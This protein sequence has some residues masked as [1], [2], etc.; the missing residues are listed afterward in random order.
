MQGNIQITTDRLELSAGTAEMLRA[1]VGDRT[2]LPRLLDAQV[3]DGW[4]PPL[5]DE[6]SMAIAL[7]YIEQN[8]DAAGW[9]FWY[10]ILRQGPAGRIAI[11]NGG[12][13]GKPDPDGAVEI[14]YS[15]MEGYQRRGYGT[16][17][18]R[19]MIGWAFEHPEIERVI[20]E[21]LPELTGSIRVLEKNGFTNIGQGSEPGIIRF[22]LKRSQFEMNHRE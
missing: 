15:I 4:P 7:N 14:G 21:T 19:G 20:A 8:P 22:E 6:R 2:A 1:E 16:E 13:K 12:F 18:V 11:G 10:F 5:N 9:G 3:P 17:I